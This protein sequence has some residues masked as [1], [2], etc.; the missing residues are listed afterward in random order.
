[1]EEP[2]W[3]DAV[4]GIAP[5]PE[6]WSNQEQWRSDKLFVRSFFSV[7]YEWILE[8]T[9][10]LKLSKADALVLF[11]SLADFHDEETIHVRDRALRIALWN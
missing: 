8:E 6:E 3:R 1:M 5:D 9:V 2:C 4:A 11:D 7:I 10:E